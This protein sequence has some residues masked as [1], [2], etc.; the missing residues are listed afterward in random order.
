MAANMTTLCD[1][2][3]GRKAKKIKDLRNLC[4]KVSFHLTI[5]KEGT[6]EYVSLIIQNISS[7]HIFFFVIYSIDMIGAVEEDKILYPLSEKF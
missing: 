4:W 7:G 2:I 1:S 3:E 6:D 5:D